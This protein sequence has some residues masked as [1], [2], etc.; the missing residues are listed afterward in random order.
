MATVKATKAEK[1]Q[2]I[3]VYL[4]R[5]NGSEEDFVRVGVNGKMY[6]IP[7]GKTSMVTRPVYE[8]L[9]RSATA[10]AVTEAYVRD[11]EYAELGK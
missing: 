3:A 6:Q 9:R 4:D 8:V 7:R 11:N 5:A 10:R 2:K 1:E